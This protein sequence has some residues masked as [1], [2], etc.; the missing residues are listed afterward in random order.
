MTRPPP[1]KTHLNP[2]SIVGTILFGGV[3]ISL[4][5]LALLFFP[6]AGFLG[7]FLDLLGSLNPFRRSQESSDSPATKN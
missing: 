2:F 6:L 4:T 1:I 7:S 5:M 3:T